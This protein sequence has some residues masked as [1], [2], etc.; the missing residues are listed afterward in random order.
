MHRRTFARENTEIDS[1]VTVLFIQKINTK[2]NVNPTS[3]FLNIL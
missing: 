1:F 2:S 3:L